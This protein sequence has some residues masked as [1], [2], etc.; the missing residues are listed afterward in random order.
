[1]TKRFII[2]SLLI[3]TALASIAQDI[4]VFYKGKLKGDFS[5]V[6]GPEN[7]TSI[8]TTITD[9]AL[10]KISFSGEESWG[11]AFLN[12]DEPIDVSQTRYIALKLRADTNLVFEEIGFGERVDQ[13][14]RI[15]KMKLTKE[16]VSL[17]IELPQAMQTVKV[18]F[19]IASIHKVAIDI[20][21]IRYIKELP[22]S[23][24]NVRVLQSAPQER[25]ENVK[26]IYNET[27]EYGALSGYA[28]EKDGIS[29]LIDDHN[30]FKPYRGKYCIKIAVDDAESWRALF[31]Q[32]TG[33]WTETLSD[34]TQ[35]ASL[36]DYKKLVF[37]ARTDEKD[38]FIPEV[39][40]GSSTNRFSQ[41][42]RNLVYV[43]VTSKW[44]RFELDIRGL[45]RTS[46]NDVMTLT[47][48]EGILYL[49][50]IRFEK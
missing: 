22:A 48:N 6:E 40:F 49:D 35:L 19:V 23:L 5:K 18:P 44:K 21:Y 9:D 24:E 39:G 41:E 15:K 29:M 37:Y 28:G 20:E 38:Y 8:S 12:L 17:I 2:I 31:F 27:S 25:L 46:V 1:M 30:M 34:E 10:L 43:K 45:E 13:G 14:E 4:D 47:L 36:K 32:V 50:E 3:T 11:R 26:Y 16:W 7:G 42:Q 33:K